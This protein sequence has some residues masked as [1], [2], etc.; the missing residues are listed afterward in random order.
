MHKRVRRDTVEYLRTH[1]ADFLYV[2]TCLP[3]FAAL[4]GVG[5]VILCVSV[6]VCFF[7]FYAQASAA[8]LHT[9]APRLFSRSIAQYCNLFVHL[10]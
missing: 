5:S 3:A 6:N 9:L 7:L 4:C 10:C 8:Y 1:R 2:F